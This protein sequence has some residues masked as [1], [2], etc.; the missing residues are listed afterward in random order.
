MENNE[1][2]RIAVEGEPTCETCA[3]FSGTKCLSC[4]T[5]IGATFKHNTCKYHLVMT[6]TI[7]IPRIIKIKNL[8]K[9]VETGPLQFNNDWPGTFIR[10]NSSFFYAMQLGHIKQMIENKETPGL[11]E[12]SA[13]DSLIELLESSKL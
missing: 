4:D 2:H 12:M 6:E 13:L 1:D 3:S 11:M 8:K 7:N 9:R 10:G 5:T